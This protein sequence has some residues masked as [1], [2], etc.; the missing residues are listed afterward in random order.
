MADVV[1]NR[2]GLVEVVKRH[3]PNG[4]LAT[5]AEVLN[6]TNMILSDIVW[7]EGNDIWSNKTVR[8]S[9]LPTGTWRKFNQGVA[10]ESSGTI[11]LVDTIGLL[12][13]RSENDVEIINSFSDPKQARM[14]EAAPFVE[15]MG[16]EMVATLFYG[17]SLTAPEEFTGLAPR[18]AALAASTNVI[19]EGGSGG[20]TTSIYVVTWSPLTAFCAYPRNSAA[21]LD[22]QDLGEVDA[23]DSNSRKFRAFADLFKWKCGL[24]VKHPRAIARLANI[25]VS[26]STNTFDEDNLITL[27]NRMVTGPG[28]RIYC[29]TDVITQMEIRVKDKNNVYYSKEDGLAPGFGLRFKGFPVRKVDQILNTETAVA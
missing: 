12:E 17:N 26:G 3:D 2:L 6:E 18:M 11:E 20:D 4:N 25:E 28:T 9:S 29:N 15:G 1:D 24:V 13:S 10:I 7:K 16:Q 19:N 27:I 8:R 23:W 5:I 21:G 22:H 14:D